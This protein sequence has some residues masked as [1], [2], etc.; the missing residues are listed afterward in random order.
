MFIP[1]TKADR[2]AMLQVI[3]VDRLEDLFQDIPEDYRFPELNLPAAI[4]EM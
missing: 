3:G 1:H 2:E 4:S